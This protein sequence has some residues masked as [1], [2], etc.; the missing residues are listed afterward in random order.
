MLKGHEWI[1]RRGEEELHYHV[2]FVTLKEDISLV[3]EKNCTHQLN[4][5]N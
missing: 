5:A 3:H 2:I 4:K 1:V